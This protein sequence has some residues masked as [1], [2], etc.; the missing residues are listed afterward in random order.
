VGEEW[1]LTVEL[2]GGPEEMVSLV[3]ELSERLPEGARMTRDA[4]TIRVYSFDEAAAARIE[5]VALGLLDRSG[6]GYELWHDRWDEEESEWEEIAP[7]FPPGEEPPELA[8]PE[9]PAEAEG[10]E[11]AAATEGPVVPQAAGE[12]APAGG[13]P[14]AVNSIQEAGALVVLRFA[15]RDAGTELRARLSEA[16]IPLVSRRRGFGVPAADEGAAAQLAESLR[17][18]APP[19]TSIETTVVPDRRA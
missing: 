13:F 10:D 5:A 16:G 3:G 17:A 19:G 15:D 6:L 2:D 1:R 11:V 4:A 18:Q 9:Q 14:G 8:Q 12:E 7:D